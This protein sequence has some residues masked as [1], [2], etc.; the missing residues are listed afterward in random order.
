MG[1]L[2]STRAEK[3]VHM[4]FDEAKFARFGLLAGLVFAVLLAVSGALGGSPPMVSDGDQKILEYLTDKQ[5]QLKIASYLGGLGTVFFLW[6]LGSLYG[7]LRGAEG[8]SGRLSRVAMMGG[9]S[10]IAIASAANAISASAALR[11]NPGAYRLSTQFYGYTA[12][13]IAVFVAAISVHIWSS[14]I[15]PKWFGYVGEALALAWFVAGAM[16]STEND[17]I[18][19][20]G[21]IV[22]VAFAI[23][24]AVL[25]V[26]LY[27]NAE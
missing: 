3:G 26:M 16:V 9:V 2:V 11:P 20:I 1:A 25:S 6:F 23:W 22:V 21:F 18:H 27:R 19:T 10:A 7:R 13:A 17:T 5:D 14:G 12:F 4:A 24:V 8:G 15:L